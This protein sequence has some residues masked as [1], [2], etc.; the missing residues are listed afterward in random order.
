MSNEKKPIVVV[1]DLFGEWYYTE[2]LR[3]P[4]TNPTVQE[5]CQYMADK[6]RIDELADNQEYL[7]LLHR[8]LGI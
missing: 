7:L 1:L 2:K 6:N 4:D 8:A 3:N 5:F